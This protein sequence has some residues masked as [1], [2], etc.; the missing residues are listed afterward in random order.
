MKPKKVLLKRLLITNN[1]EDPCN[2]GYLKGR[3]V[4]S[5][6]PH[7]WGRGSTCSTAPSGSISGRRTEERI[8][9]AVLALAA[10]A[11]PPFE[12]APKGRC[13]RPI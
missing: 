3:T 5:R 6:R 11:N 2:N 13:I 9:E 12:E 7:W 10:T 4:L 1:N 8:A